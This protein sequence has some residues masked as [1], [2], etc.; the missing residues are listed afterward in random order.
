MKITQHR[1]DVIVFSCTSDESCRRILYTLQTS[2]E[3]LADTSWHCDIVTLW[4]R[5]IVTTFHF[6]LHA[7]RRK[8]ESRVSQTCGVST[9][10]LSIEPT[11]HYITL[12]YRHFKRHLHL[13]WPVVHQQLHVIRNTAHRPS[14][15]ASYTASR[16]RPKRKISCAVAQIA[17]T[18]IAATLTISFP[19]WRHMSLTSY[20]GQQ[21]M[22]LTSNPGPW[23]W[24]PEI[25]IQNQTLESLGRCG[26]TQLEAATI[27]R[28]L[29]SFTALMFGCSG[30]YLN[31]WPWNKRWKLRSAS[32]QRSRSSVPALHGWNA[33]ILPLNHLLRLQFK[34]NNWIKKLLQSVNKFT[35]CLRKILI[36]HFCWVS[37][38]KLSSYPPTITSIH[39]QAANV[40]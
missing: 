12:H 1:R 38:Y 14:T 27:N 30:T 2:E 17:A 33:R 3:V 13:Q 36:H 24:Q 11:Q 34:N 7:I 9:W 25:N 10:A 32:R 37:W 19:R 18:Q 4:H 20:W 15:Q 31:S 39:G 40:S 6:W 35:T 16:V 21:R 26:H 28:L 29:A 23:V 8:L 22:S 5:D